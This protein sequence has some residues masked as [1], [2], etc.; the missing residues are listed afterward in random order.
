VLGPDSIEQADTKKKRET[1]MNYDII[2]D[3]HGHADAL[4]ALLQHMDYKERAGAW[5]HSDRKAIFV[6]DFIDRGPKQVESVEIVRRMVEAGSAQAVMGNHEFNA[7]GWFL[8]DERNPGEYLRPHHSE[9]YGDKNF[10]QHKAFLNE[11]I[12]TPR[13]K[14]IVDWFLTLPLWLDL[15]GL[16]VVH[17]CWHQKFIAFL[18]PKLASGQRLTTHLMVEASREPVDEAEKDT[19]E[20]SVFKAVEALTKGIE[21]PLPDG[22][23][24]KDKDGHPRKRVRVRWWDPNAVTYRQTAILDDIAR[25]E[26]PEILIPDHVLIGDGGGKPIFIGHYWWTGIPDRL[27][28]KVGCVDYSIAR[29]GKLVAYRWDGENELSDEKFVSVG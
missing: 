11:V 19:P 14:E 9:K 26:L 1:T 2:G 18:A 25:E 10:Q 15:P 17:A 6:G 29:G 22:H 7:I 21:I 12:G 28:R 23:T 4:K 3:I 13:H 24:F 20:P 27:T 8:R 16:R 5:R